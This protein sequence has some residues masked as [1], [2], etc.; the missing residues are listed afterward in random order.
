ML[1]C[2]I[3]FRYKLTSS[4]LAPR[5]CQNSP[6]V[7]FPLQV[8]RPMVDDE[9]ALHVRPRVKDTP[10]PSYSTV[11]SR[12]SQVWNDKTRIRFL[13]RLS[14]PRSGRNVFGYHHRLFWADILLRRYQNRTPRE[15]LEIL[16]VGLDNTDDIPG[17]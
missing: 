6:T 15:H 8:G 12:S 10:A 1:R 4:A 5:V 9:D 16:P 14:V 11:S 3:V 7:Y 17:E 13:Q 2:I